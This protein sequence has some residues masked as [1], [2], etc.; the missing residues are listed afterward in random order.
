M[1]HIETSAFD[2]HLNDGLILL[3]HS[4]LNTSVGNVDVG[5]NKINDMRL[6]KLC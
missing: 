6:L 1:T 2:D 5:L 3:K 4:P